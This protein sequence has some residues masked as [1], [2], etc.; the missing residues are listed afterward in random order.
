MGENGILFALFFG[1]T[2]F[3]TVE[4]TNVFLEF[5]DELRA[6]FVFPMCPNGELCLCDEVLLFA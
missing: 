5:L 1:N 2:R 6:A 4:C 3:V